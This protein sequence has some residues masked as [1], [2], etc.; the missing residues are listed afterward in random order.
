MVYFAAAHM[1]WGW[2]GA[3]PHPGG[4]R[5]GWGLQETL[6]WTW[7]TSAAG[8]DGLAMSAHAVSFV[9]AV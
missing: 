4:W 6:A 1:V 2:W 5:D 3:G 7:W 9:E 8:A